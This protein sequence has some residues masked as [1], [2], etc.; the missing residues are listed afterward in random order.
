MSFATRSICGTTYLRGCVSRPKMRLILLVVV[1]P[2]LFSY[3]C[4]WNWLH[5]Y[6]CVLLQV[7]VSNDNI[8][9]SNGDALGQQQRQ[10]RTHGELHCLLRSQ[11][12]LQPQHLI[13]LPEP[14]LASN[15]AP[16]I[17]QLSRLLRLETFSTAASST[18]SFPLSS[19]QWNTQ[20]GQWDW[21]LP[22]RTTNIQQQQQEKEEKERGTKN[23]SF[24]L[25]EA[26]E[27]GTVVIQSMA[28]G[29]S[30]K[31][32][33]RKRS[34]SSNDNI[35]DTSVNKYGFRTNKHKHRQNEYST[36][37]LIPFTTG[38]FLT[39]NI[40][41]FVYYWQHQIDPSL[42]AVN[43]DAI[44]QK[45]DFGRAFTG[46]LAHFEIWHLGMN[47]MSAQSLG[48]SVL[49]PSIGSIPLLLYTLSFL[50]LTTLVVVGIYQGLKKFSSYRTTIPNMVGFSGILFSWMVVATLQSSHPEPQCPIF[51]LPTLCFE[52]YTVFGQKVSISPLIQLLVMQVILPRV[53]F[54]GHL[55]GLIVGFLWHF[56]L[57]PSIEW[58]QPCILYPILWV[59]GTQFT[60]SNSSS[61]ASV[62][63]IHPLKR[64]LNIMGFH[65]LM[66]LLTSFPQWKNSLVVSEILLVGILFWFRLQMRSATV[67]AGQSNI[68]RCGTISV[69]TFAKGYTVLILVVWMTDNLTLG[70]LMAMRVVIWHSSFDYGMTLVQMLCR[71]SLWW[72]TLTI[73]GTIAGGKKTTRDINV[74]HSTISPFSQIDSGSNNV[75]SYA[76][77]WWIIE[78]W[79][80]NNSYFVTGLPPLP[81]CCKSWKAF[82]ANQ[83][84]VY[85]AEQH[86]NE[87]VSIVQQQHARSHQHESVE[88]SPII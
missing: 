53:S 44:L 41:L 69:D 47:M 77:I 60:T 79:C 23:D 73:V 51:F 3:V 64:L 32:S 59:F 4:F 43:V 74:T 57:F 18:S 19:T 36:S 6:S 39:I 20:T 55:A 1:L 40:G 88:T 13:L 78:P 33:N 9:Y 31:P 8:N 17:A 37:S 2:F 7:V 34:K 50:P 82:A 12:A 76:V 66:V 61:T 5:T 48:G 80:G 38:F 67:T 26:E 52:T 49:E 25:S 21:Q 14:M 56:R 86:E 70:G 16:T 46:N 72:Y 45:G 62:N 68:S 63:D 22:T 15:L 81:R 84:L 58:I 65:C 10:Q 27:E 35:E 42:V 75:I 28:Y 30:S 71:Q 85:T 54:V 87:M 11:Y 24:S 83:R 29:P